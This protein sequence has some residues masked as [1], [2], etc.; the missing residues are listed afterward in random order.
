MRDAEEFAPRIVRL[1]PQDRS[2]VV[3][4]AVTPADALDRRVRDYLDEHPEA[5]QRQV[6]E[7]VKGRGEDIRAAYPRVRPV[8]P[9][10]GRTSGQGASQGGASYRDAS[11]RSPSADLRRRWLVMEQLPLFDQSRRLADLS[12]DQRHAGALVVLDGDADLGVQER[13]DLLL[14]VVAPGLLAEVER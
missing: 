9:S 6:E 2:L 14:L 11:G 3:V 10:T 8:R 4:E 12:L 13:R 5:S 7:N 1:I